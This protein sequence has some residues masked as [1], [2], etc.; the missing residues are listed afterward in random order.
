MFG[1]LE[2]TLRTALM[3]ILCALY[4]TQV[5][6]EVK[7]SA[8][9]QLFGVPFPDPEDDVTLQ[10]DHPSWIAEYEEFISQN[11]EERISVLM[12]D[13]DGELHEQQITRTELE[14]FLNSLLDPSVESDQGFTM[15][16]LSPDRKLH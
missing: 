13:E 9:L 1:D 5:V 7:M 11:T 6:K 2:P 14:S 10:F 16:D 8:V 3:R 4:E 15:S 12:Q